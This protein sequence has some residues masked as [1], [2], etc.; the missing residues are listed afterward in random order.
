MA[1]PGV[2]AEP[3]WPRCAV[4]DAELEE[5]IDRKTG[6]AVREHGRAMLECPRCGAVSIGPSPVS[7]RRRYFAV[8]VVLALAG[9]VSGIGVL[10]YKVAQYRGAE[11]FRSHQFYFALILLACAGAMGHLMLQS[12]ARAMSPNRADVRF[13]CGALVVF[14][15]AWFAMIVWAGV[16]IVKPDSR[17]QARRQQPASTSIRP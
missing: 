10:A 8:R 9:F 12:L 13:E 11:G 7:Q 16:Q 3:Q 6:K 15:A 17:D 1:E 5:R 4:C 14:Y 2:M